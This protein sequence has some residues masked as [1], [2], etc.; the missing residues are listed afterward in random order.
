MDAA[1]VQGVRN[2]LPQSIYNLTV[3]GGAGQSSCMRRRSLVLVCGALLTLAGCG[4]DVEDPTFNSDGPGGPAGTAA[5]SSSSSEG[6]DTDE[7]DDDADA[8]QGQDESEADSSP[9]MTDDGDPTTGPV[10]DTGD[11]NGDGGGG[12]G[13]GMVSPGE[14][15]DGADLQGFDCNSLG[16]NGGSLSCDPVTCTFDTSM[17]GSSSGGSSG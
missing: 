8:D 5:S 9:P 1:H 7:E 6:G 2:A 14:Q 16:L 11:D 17:C 10:G 3:S 12:C 4:K 15:C 13:N